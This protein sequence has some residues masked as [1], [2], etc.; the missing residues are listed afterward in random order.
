VPAIEW[1][2]A[3]KRFAILVLVLF[4][5]LT[6]KMSLD[7]GRQYACIGGMVDADSLGLL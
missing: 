4:S 6:P 5:D 2:L 3:K 7:S 1:Q